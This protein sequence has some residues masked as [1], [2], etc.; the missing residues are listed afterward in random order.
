MQN[1]VEEDEPLLTPD[2]VCKMLGGI[3]QK[4]LCDWNNHHRHRATLSPIR[5]SNKVVRYE[6][7]NVLAFIDRCRSQ[8]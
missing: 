7:K 2:E 5:F 4:T 6:K 1:K 3:T 8:Y